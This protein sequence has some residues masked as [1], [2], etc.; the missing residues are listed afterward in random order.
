MFLQEQAHVP[1]LVG[2]RSEVVLWDFEAGAAHSALRPLVSRFG[3][4]ALGQFLVSGG[5]FPDGSFRM[6]TS[7]RGCA[8]ESLGLAM[9]RL[10]LSRAHES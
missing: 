5:G 10:G 7:G 2:W 1:G 9:C 3:G 4:V 6:M 8:T